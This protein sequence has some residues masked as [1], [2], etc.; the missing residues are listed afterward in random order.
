MSINNA[1]ITIH[2]Q[3]NNSSKNKWVYNSKIEIKVQNKLNFITCYNDFE[4]LNQ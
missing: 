1:P 3:T 4:R 2:Y